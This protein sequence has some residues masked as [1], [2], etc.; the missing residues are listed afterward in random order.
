MEIDYIYYKVIIYSRT[1]GGRKNV[2]T[3]SQFVQISWIVEIRNFWKNAV[4]ILKSVIPS[5][6]INWK[7]WQDYEQVD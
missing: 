5:Q 2:Y 1:I 6:L 3:D 7:S 4:F